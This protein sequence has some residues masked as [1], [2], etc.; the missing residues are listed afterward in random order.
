MLPSSA[1]SGCG[2]RP[3]ALE[4]LPFVREQQAPG[5][6]RPSRGPGHRRPPWPPWR[7]EPENHRNSDDGG[8]TNPAEVPARQF[9][10]TP[11][12]PTAE[13]VERAGPPQRVPIPLLVEA[14]VGRQAA[15]LP[16]GLQDSRGPAAWSRSGPASCLR[17]RGS[18]P[19]RRLPRRSSSGPSGPCFQRRHDGRAQGLDFA[20]GHT[21]FD[22][23][24]PVT[25]GVGLPRP[26]RER[27][28]A[29]R[30]HV[31]TPASRRKFVNLHARP[32]RRP[33][34]RATGRPERTGPGTD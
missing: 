30:D 16:V 31:G 27:E 7:P 6:H 3:L 4:R 14:S 8:R 24:V 32:A 25:V 20:S 34:P 10:R 33:R 29:R 28:V 19:L 2:R 23:G 15:D 1:Y 5:P 9:D 22:C 21:E 18:A 26:K 11:H 12:Q 13:L 17:R